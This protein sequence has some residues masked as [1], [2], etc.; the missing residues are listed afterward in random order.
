MADYLTN[1]LGAWIQKHQPTMIDKFQNATKTRKVNA[2]QSVN[3]LFDLKDGDLL[4]TQRIRYLLEEGSSL[5]GLFFW[6]DELMV[7]KSKGF[8][9][10][11][12]EIVERAEHGQFSLENLFWI[13]SIY[14]RPQIPS[15][16]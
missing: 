1:D 5:D 7:R 15:P 12:F 6:L 2:S 4:V 16:L 14:M 13:S 10:L 8:E 3:S 9:P 11:L